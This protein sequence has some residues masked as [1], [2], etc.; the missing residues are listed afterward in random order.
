MTRGG[1]GPRLAWGLVAGGVL[2]GT[3][4]AA[5]GPAGP[6]RALYD[7]L[8]PLPPYRWVQPPRDLARDNQPPS[9]GA[10]AL[11]LDPSGKS[12]GS[13]A[14]GDGQCT[15]IFNDGAV[16]AGPSG[17]TLTVTI[18]A[19]DPAALGAPPRGTRFDGN[20]CRFQ[21][22][23]GKSRVVPRYR[24]TVTIVLRYATGGTQIARAGE[25]GW[26]RVQT[27]RYA[28]HLHLLVANVPTLGTFA[29]VAAANT[30]YVQAAS[31]ERDAAVAALV[32]FA[33]LVAMRARRPR[34][35]AG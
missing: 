15:V 32:I 24:R 4:L 8:V 5:A 7:G 1:R 21:A 9:P 11:D 14:T 27:I 3:V 26:Q 31:W 18:A 20:A 34:K 2:I 13:V 16:A 22:A 19:L 12:P 17:G 30:P 35:R 28:G 6:G 23:Y 25:S 10:A 33:I 29:P